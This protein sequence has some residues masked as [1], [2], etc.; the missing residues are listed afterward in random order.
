MTTHEHT[1]HEHL[2]HEH[3]E[4]ERTAL[5]QL[6]NEILSSIGK[7]RRAPLPWGSVTVSVILGVLAI[8]SLVQAV[9]S[10]SLYNKL[11]SGDLKST[12]AA[13]AS[14]TGSSLPSQ[15]GGC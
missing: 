14:G 11:K 5:D 10:A 1:T 3:L 2:E 7:E 13:P 9:Q 4:A 12:A 6:K 15:V 8:I